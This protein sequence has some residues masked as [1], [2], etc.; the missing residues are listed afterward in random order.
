M[1]NN[2]LV[3]DFRNVKTHFSRQLALQAI[4]SL[5]QM[6]QATILSLFEVLKKFYEDYD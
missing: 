4:D 6:I 3:M 2:A 5:E 1:S